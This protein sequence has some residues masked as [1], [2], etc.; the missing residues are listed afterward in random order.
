[1]ENRHLSA[2]SSHIVFVTAYTYYLPGYPAP[3]TWT[4]TFSTS[5]PL[6]P[7]L[8]TE[9]SRFNSGLFPTPACW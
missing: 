1:M 2:L 7:H 6:S 9:F 8:R 5:H 3:P 4:R